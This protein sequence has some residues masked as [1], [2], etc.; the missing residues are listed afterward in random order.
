VV[1]QSHKTY[2][3]KKTLGILKSQGQKMWPDLPRESVTGHAQKFTDRSVSALC[4]LCTLRGKYLKQQIIIHE[5]HEHRDMVD[6]KKRTEERD[7]KEEINESV[8]STKCRKF[9]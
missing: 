6:R 9:I 1:K 8:N 7:R 4:L 5:Y 3:Y 2:E